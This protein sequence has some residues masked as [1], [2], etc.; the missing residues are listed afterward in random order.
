MVKGPPLSVETMDGLLD[1]PR[2]EKLKIGAFDLVTG[3]STEAVENP[4]PDGL[5]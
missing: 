1:R 2:Q 4:M 3:S 5:L